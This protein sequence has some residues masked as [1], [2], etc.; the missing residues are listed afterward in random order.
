MRG[1]ESAVKQ[2]HGSLNLV[3]SGLT[4]KPIEHVVVSL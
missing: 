2:D 3:P 4:V 1:D